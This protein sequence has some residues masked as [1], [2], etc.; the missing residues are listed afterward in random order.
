MYGKETWIMTL[1]IEYMEAFQKQVDII[2]LFIFPFINFNFPKWN[3]FNI[4]TTFFFLN[5]LFL[6][7]AIDTMFHPSGIFKMAWK[8]LQ[9]FMFKI[10]W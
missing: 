1:D 7:L 9:N 10:V 5:D 2:N 3:M 8:F 4:Y 6:Y